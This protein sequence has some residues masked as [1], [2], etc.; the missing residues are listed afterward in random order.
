MVNTSKK[1]TTKRRILKA[2]AKIISERGVFALTLDA[3]AAEAQISKGGLLYH[4]AG[5]DKLMRAM[6][7][8]IM[9][10][11]VQQI[12]AYAAVD[13]C[14]VG[15]WTR[16]YLKTTFEQ[17][18]TDLE[19]NAAFLSAVAT[20]TTL[21]EEM[22]ADFNELKK[23]IENDGLDP[24]K[25]NVVRLAVDGLY[26]NQ[27]YG[28]TLTEREQAQLLPYLLAFTYEDSSA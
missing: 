14:I 18:N 20:D 26:Y 2:A 28:I 22:A 15:R 8:F 12:H 3:V 13:P 17:I 7:N 5:K 4:F 10:K 16:G 27:L 9:E 6:K 23:H 1:I 24:L 11:F 25:A 21:V 19:M